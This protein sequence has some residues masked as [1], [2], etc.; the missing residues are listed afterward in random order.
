MNIADNNFSSQAIAKAA[1]TVLETVNV[2]I[3][4]PKMQSLAVATLLLVLCKHL[5]IDGHDALNYATRIIEEKQMNTER[6][7][8]GALDDFVVNELKTKLL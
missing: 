2:K 8:F 6:H 1:Y 4:N 5:K 7:I 3:E